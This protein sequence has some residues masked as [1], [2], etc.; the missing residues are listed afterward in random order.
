MEGRERFDGFIRLAEFRLK[1]WES[2][3]AYEWKISLGLWGLLAATA[4]YVPFRPNMTAVA[5]LLITI[6]LIYTLMW[7]GPILVRNDEDMATAF[8]YMQKAEKELDPTTEVRSKP[9]QQ[10]SL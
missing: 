3:R 10:L 1:R 9:E 5:F 8:Y 2:R 7:A 4:Y 6:F